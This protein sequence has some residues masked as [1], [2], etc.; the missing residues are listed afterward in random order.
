MGVHAAA[1][2]GRVGYIELV[3]TNRKFRLLWVGQIISLLG[4]WFDLIASAALV[5]S[6]TGSG[7]AVGGLF[8]VRMLA[9]FVLSPIA[10]VASDR[11]NR[12]RLMIFSDITRGITVLGFLLVRSASDVWLIYAL[13]ALQLG[14]SAFFF[15]AR[16]AILPD[17]TTRQELGAANAIS[18]VTW[19]VMLAFGAA[20][21]GLSAGIVG[22]YPAF[23]ID[24]LSFFLSAF[25]I[26]Q[27]IYQR[28]AA[29]HGTDRTIMGGFRQYFDGLRYLRHN[30]DI[31]FIA[32]HKAANSLFVVGGFQVVQVAITER[33]F[34]IGEGGGISLGLMYAAVGIG[35]GVGPIL[36][37]WF[38]GDHDRP[39]RSAILISYI[40][41]VVGLLM[42]ATL[43]NFPVVL[44]GSV[45]R[46]VGG[47]IGWVFSTQLLLQ[48]APDRVR[49][50]V[51]STEFALYS[52]MNAVGAGVAGGML[53]AQVTIMALTVLM[54]ALTIVPTILWGL[55]MVFGTSA[56]PVGDEGS[57]P[58]PI[59]INEEIVV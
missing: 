34:V 42:V 30:L 28:P 13:S 32:L 41:S 18:S 23:L 39:L 53:D 10:G 2:Q 55:W 49:G 51:F 52:L 21:G 26:S 14:L 31:F 4:D 17:I 1:Q 11:Y 22:I 45:L 38:T 36:A 6:L 47:G 27:V 54:A 20:L 9:P 8:V 59:E 43:A 24:A 15:P 7:T 25:F 29:I 19:S 33:I 46:G 56:Q 58:Q 5:A 12:K 35:T 3:R 50:R 57:E 48:L 16:N 40:L 37:R 44:M